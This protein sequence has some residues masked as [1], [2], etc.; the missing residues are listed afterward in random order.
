MWCPFASL[1]NNATTTTEA[2]ETSAFLEAVAD[3]VGLGVAAAAE[4]A[5]CAGLLLPLLQL[6]LLL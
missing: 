3:L 1:C 5:S 4:S 6:V 2:D